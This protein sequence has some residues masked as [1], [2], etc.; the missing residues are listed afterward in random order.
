MVVHNEFD[1]PSRQPCICYPPPLSF[2]SPN[3]GDGNF[4]P[5]AEV[6]WG[7]GVA[8]KIYSVAL[9]HLYIA[10]EASHTVDSVSLLN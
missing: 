5:I 1:G 9:E 7:S 10:R 8:R 3:G 6:T 4:T 2:A